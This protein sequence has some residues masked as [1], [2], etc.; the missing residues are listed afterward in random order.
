MR[1][2][3]RFQ[4][5]EQSMR[6]LILFQA[7][8]SLAFLFASSVFARPP[9]LVRFAGIPK[10]DG[11]PEA[12]IGLRQRNASDVPGD[13]SFAGD[14]FRTRGSNTLG[15]ALRSL[16]GGR[17]QVRL[18][19][20]PFPHPGDKGAYRSCLDDEIR[21]QKD[22]SHK[23]FSFTARQ[24]AFCTWDTVMGE[25]P[26]F[27]EL[28]TCMALEQQ[29]AAARRENAKPLRFRQLLPLHALNDDA[30]PLI[31]AAHCASCLARSA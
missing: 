13:D 12:P 2:R 24:R 30:T 3:G 17:H 16:R 25:A 19:A 28:L 27:V 1:D 9:A 5:E 7:M 18:P 26:S 8:T 21:V 4:L 11:V 6:P 31:S 10:I 20:C 23:W 14:P 22:F 29:A 15:P